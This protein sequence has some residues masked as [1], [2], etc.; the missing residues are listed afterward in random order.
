M[1]ELVVDRYIHTREY[2][3]IYIYIY[4]FF[5]Y[6]MYQDFP[7]FFFF[8]LFGL[9]YYTRYRDE[10]VEHKTYLIVIK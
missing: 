1:A 5:F 9:A 6:K 2:I 8:F 7:F 10:Q 3:Y 4:F